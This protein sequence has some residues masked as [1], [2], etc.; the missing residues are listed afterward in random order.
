MFVSA[1]LCV[2]VFLYLH[3]MIVVIEFKFRTSFIQFLYSE[4]FIHRSIEGNNFSGTIPPEI[5]NLIHLEKLYFF[6]TYSWTFLLQTYL[7]KSSFLFVSTNVISLFLF[8]TLSSNAFTGNLP[9]TFGKLKN[10]T[11]MWAFNIWY[12]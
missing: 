12:F 2:M 7:K 11:D 5:G 10:L 1:L 6:F 4:F 3:Q 8:S 9:S